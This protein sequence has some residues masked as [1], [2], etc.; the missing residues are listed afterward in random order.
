MTGGIKNKFFPNE[1]QKMIKRWKE[2]KGD[3]NLILNHPELSKKSVVFDL[4]GYKGQWTSDIY[5]KYN[6]IVYVFEPVK[7]FYEYMKNRFKENKKI[8]VFNFALASSNRIES[9][10]LN[11]SASSIYGK[12]KKERINL[13]DFEDFLKKE[14]IREIDL[15]EINIEGAENEL[16][17]YIINR[18][19]I[20][21]IKNLQVQFHRN[22]K[23]YEE[24]YREIKEKLGKTHKLNWYFPFVWES[25]KKKNA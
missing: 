4:G 5:S 14:K 9:I 17:D 20:K 21:R 12:N 13:I 16:L 6:C 25:W 10:S 7:K 11:G 22:I 24:K 3:E 1:H 19:S 23:N 18:E 2:M 8:K 15:M